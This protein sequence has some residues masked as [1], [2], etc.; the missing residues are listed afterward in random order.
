MLADPLE[1][2]GDK[3]LDEVFAHMM[4]DDS[5]L[6]PEIDMSAKNFLSNVVNEVDAN[7]M[8]FL[9]QYYLRA[10]SEIKP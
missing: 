3:T 2:D 9:A 6:Y 5:S 8:V 10:F 4:E 1:V 7:A